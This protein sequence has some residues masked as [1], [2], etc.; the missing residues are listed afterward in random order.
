MYIV[1][2][3]AVTDLIC[4]FQEPLWKLHYF[5]ITNSKHLT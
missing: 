3:K 4:K 5:V 2:I 1:I